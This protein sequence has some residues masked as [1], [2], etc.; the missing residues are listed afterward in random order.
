MEGKQ[1]ETINFR[2]MKTCLYSI[3]FLLLCTTACKTEVDDEK[4]EPEKPKSQSYNIINEKEQEQEFSSGEA[5][6]YNEKALA[7]VQARDYKSA[8]ELFK[9]SLEIEPNSPVVYNN[10]G[11]IAVNK[12]QVQLASDYFQQSIKLDSFYYNPYVNYSSLLLENDYFDKAILY[13]SFVIKRCKDKQLVALAHFI[14]AYAYLMK[15]DCN[16]ARESSEGAKSLENDP[17]YKA[18]LN[19]L[20]QKIA[21]CR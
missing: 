7:F 16:K 8:R 19:D 15:G 14:N 6:A 3:L 17:G 1:H 4:K 18:Q 13:N 10:L 20:L 21:S 11:L 5:S 12:N 2:P 9:K